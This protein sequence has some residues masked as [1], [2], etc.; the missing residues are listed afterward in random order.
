MRNIV[1]LAAACVCA[2]MLSSCTPV[3]TNEVADGLEITS[4]SPAAI[5]KSVQA[6]PETPTEPKTPVA[7]KINDDPRRLLGLDTKSL[8]VLLGAPGFTRRDPPAQ[9]WRYRDKSCILDLYLYEISKKI[10]G[11]T[12]RH[13][14]ARSPSNTYMPARTCFRALLTARTRKRIAP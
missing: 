2:I 6:S 9:L 3:A 12:V 13:Y 4:P 1:N 14:E 5:S 8:T 7:V 11:S 10:T